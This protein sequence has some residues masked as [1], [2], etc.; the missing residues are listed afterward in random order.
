MTD[1]SRPTEDGDLTDEQRA[2]LLIVVAHYCAFHKVTHRPLMEAAVR[3]RHALL[4]KRKRNSPTGRKASSATSPIEP[5]ALDKA[6][7]KAAKKDLDNFLQKLSEQ[8]TGLIYDYFRGPAREPDY[9]TNAPLQIRR[10]I[11]TLYGR[12]DGQPVS[13]SVAKTLASLRE[14]DLHF[15]ENIAHTYEGVWDLFRYGGH[16]KNNPVLMWAAMQIMRPADPK[17]PASLP[18]FVIRYRPSGDPKGKYRTADGFI[19][20]LIGQQHM[21]FI[22]RDHGTNYPLDILCDQRQLSGGQSHPNDDED[23]EKVS[24]FTGVIKR[25]H[26]QN[27]IMVSHVMG[28]RT[29]VALSDRTNLIGP[30][31]PKDQIFEKLYAEEH[32]D[33]PLHELLGAIR[34]RADHEGKAVMFL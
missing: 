11:Q 25:K 23:G 4:F 3:E 20:S 28:V 27:R 18:G 17:D 7:V 14:P 26:E 12:P 6:E 13:A 22:G 8:G 29:N 34:N 30:Y 16:G 5:T 2:L 10:A 9:Y 33:L 31:D 19:V 24:T 15:R 1:L 32:S 21:W